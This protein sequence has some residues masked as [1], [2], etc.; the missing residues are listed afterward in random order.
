[1]QEIQTSDI[2]DREDEAHEVE[3]VI[4]SGM[5]RHECEAIEAGR[6]TAT[7]TVPRLT[8]PPGVTLGPALRSTPAVQ[9]SAFDDDYRKGLLRFRRRAFR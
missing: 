2:T 8:I 1:M 6:Q 4:P 7:S 9:P 5:A 3:G